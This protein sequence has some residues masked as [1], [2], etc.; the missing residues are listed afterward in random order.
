[1]QSLL[2]L[3]IVLSMLSLAFSSAPFLPSARSLAFSPSTSSLLS[4]LLSSVPRG[5]AVLTPDTLADVD[6]AIKAAVDSGKA[7]VID[8]SATWCGPCK[9]IGPVFEL[10]SE[11][12]ADSVVFLKVDVDSNAETAQQYDVS[13]MPTFIFISAK[14]EVVDRLAGANADRLKELI[15]SLTR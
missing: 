3:T 4:S 14:G 8:F 10:L 15:S 7:V 9:M 5:G 12:F 6:A 1:M 13:A 11:E 2:L